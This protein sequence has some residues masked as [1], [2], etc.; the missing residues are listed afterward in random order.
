MNVC[1]A[2]HCLA[3][4]QSD[5]MYLDLRRLYLST[6]HALQ[7]QLPMMTSAGPLSRGIATLSHR[8]ARRST[9]MRR[10]V[11]RKLKR[12]DMI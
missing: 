4:C 5:A 12:V 3:K 6:G 11:R 10:H 9:D 8:C 2:Q 1:G 7:L